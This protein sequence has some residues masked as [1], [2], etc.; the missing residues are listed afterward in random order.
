MKYQE[1]GKSSVILAYTYISKF[2]VN[3]EFNVKK[4]IETSK[5]GVLIDEKR[6]VVGIC[7]NNNSSISFRTQ[8]TR[9]C[10]VAKP[11]EE[12]TSNFSV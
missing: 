8:N 11:R 2:D 1:R 5:Q 4:V 3:T 10:L 6:K 9:N 7:M 12:K